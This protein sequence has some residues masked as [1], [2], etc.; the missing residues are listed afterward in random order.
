MKTCVY[1]RCVHESH[2]LNAF[3]EHY[4][5]L[6]F[7][8]IYVLYN[9]TTDNDNYILPQRYSSFVTI[10][11][12]FNIGNSLYDHHKSLIDREKYQWVFI[13]DLDEFL[14]LNKSFVTIKDVI[15]HYQEKNQQVN[16][17]QFAWIWS[18][19]FSL[20]PETITDVIHGRKKMLGRL[21]EKPEV[22]YKSMIKTKYLSKIGIHNSKLTGVKSQIM[23]FNNTIKT[24]DISNQPDKHELWLLW[25]DGQEF[26]KH[27]I[28][29]GMYS[30]GFLL[31]LT[32]RN[33]CDAYSK[34][35]EKQARPEKKQR[36][37]EKVT[38]L[39]KQLEWKDLT[40]ELL[41]D[42]IEAVGYR[43]EFPLRT[44]KFGDM[45]NDTLI[46]NVRVPKNPL[47]LW[48]DVKRPKGISQKVFIKIADALD[49]FFELSQKNRN[50]I[51]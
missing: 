27:S 39:V 16:T 47:P 17:I 1:V 32:T 40:D 7:D 11:K 51:L 12:V 24:I 9:D 44:L 43:I 46:A 10:K 35:I 3:F 45:E 26:R 13:T 29:E 31:H 8:H 30:D 38:K 14:F 5:W 42:F 33:I 48:S 50:T 19:K 2:F 18:H 15:Y 28:D 37:K 36:D 25:A 34:T 20:E 22:W 21:G 4:I 49:I 6:G 41:I 23:G